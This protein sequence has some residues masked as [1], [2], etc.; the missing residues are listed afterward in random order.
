MPAGQTQSLS[1]ADIV[2]AIKK[3]FNAPGTA[4]EN[5]A[6]NPTF[7]NRSIP[8]PG[9]APGPTGPTRPTDPTSMEYMRQQNEEA[10]RRALQQKLR[11]RPDDELMRGLQGGQSGN[12]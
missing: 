5:A 1:W 10:A 3:L 4:L 2:E 6:N 8:Q 12:R 7:N 11:P 9:G